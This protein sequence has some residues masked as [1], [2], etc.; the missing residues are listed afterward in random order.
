MLVID[1]YLTSQINK[2]IDIC[3]KRKQVCERVKA[4]NI[5]REG[6]KAKELKET[7]KEKALISSVFILFAKVGSHIGL[8]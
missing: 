2:T 8:G 6:I 7:A 4:I 5:K 1:L 3:L